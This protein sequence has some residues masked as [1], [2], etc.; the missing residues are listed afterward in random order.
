V[1]RLAKKTY[2]LHSFFFFEE[3][4]RQSAD[5]ERRIALVKDAYETFRDAVLMK[6]PDHHDNEQIDKALSDVVAYIEDCEGKLRKHFDDLTC[7]LC[8]PNLSANIVDGKYLQIWAGTE[9]DLFVNCK[10]RP[11]SLQNTANTLQ[12]FANSFPPSQE[13]P[14]QVAGPLILAAKQ[15]GIQAKRIEFYAIEEEFK[16]RLAAEGYR[17]R[18]EAWGALDMLHPSQGSYDGKCENGEKAT[19]DFGNAVCK[20]MTCWKGANCD[21]PAG[22]GPHT[23][24]S[25]TSLLAGGGLQ[26]VI[27]VG[28]G[29]ADNLH[30]QLARIKLVHGSCSPPRGGHNHQLSNPPALNFASL[31]F[32]VPTF[33]A[34]DRLEW[35]VHVPNGSHGLYSVCFCFGPDCPHEGKWRQLGDIIVDPHVPLQHQ[36][37]TEFDA[38]SCD[39]DWIQDIPS[40]SYVKV[41]SNIMFRCK[42][43][44]VDLRGPQW[45][46]CTNNHWS[47][48]AADGDAGDGKELPHCKWKHTEC[49]EEKLEE[50]VPDMT[51]KVENGVATYSCSTSPT[52]EK[53]VVLTRYCQED[54]K[55]QP[56]EKP[57]CDAGSLLQLSNSPASEENASLHQ[58]HPGI[59]DHHLRIRKWPVVF[60]KDK[61]HSFYMPSNNA[62]NVLQFR[63]SIMVH[64]WM[65]TA[66]YTVMLIAAIAIGLLLPSLVRKRWGDIGRFKA[67]MWERLPA[68]VQK[69]SDHK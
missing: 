54:K 69:I 55:W 35:K 14:G 7:E 33:A 42:E 34:E 58:T 48:S 25:F 47:W 59:W 19:D 26:T 39:E 68:C 38:G 18:P 24:Q 21:Q 6:F 2:M 56:D 9:Q 12:Q 30:S 62:A 44:F 5:E 29:L 11:Q 45:L 64:A 49:P 53:K 65:R 28:C 40:V 10:D 16:K 63:P 32:Q 31:Q 41:R 27:V 37:H 57:I 67:T 43:G 13:D 61:N 46:R 50:N 36:H 51:R 60:S 4:A 66:A 8:D 15:V 1:Q 22:R 23:E 3:V 20:C 17:Y 52:G